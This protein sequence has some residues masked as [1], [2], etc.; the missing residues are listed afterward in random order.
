MKSTIPAPRCSLEAFCE[1]IGIDMPAARE[2]SVTRALCARLQREATRE[3][4]AARIAAG[5]RHSHDRD[6][7][8]T[9]YR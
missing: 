1:S 9:N 3:A 2:A 4:D 7:E 6:P 5:E 8:V